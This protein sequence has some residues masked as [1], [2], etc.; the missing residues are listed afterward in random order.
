MLG[1]WSLVLAAVGEVY[2]LWRRAPGRRGAAGQYRAP[3]NRIPRE[4]ETGPTRR[5][6]QGP[7]VACTASTLLHRGGVGSHYRQLVLA[8]RTCC[9]TIA[10]DGLMVANG[11]GEWHAARRVL[12][13]VSHCSSMSMVAGPCVD[14]FVGRSPGNPSAAGAICM[15]TRTIGAVGACVTG[16]HAFLD[17]WRA[18]RSPAYRGTEEGFRGAPL[19]AASAGIATSSLGLST[20]SM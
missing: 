18:R 8:A 15:I 4:A 1:R 12:R 9:A 5:P 2:W 10:A 7:S 19:P 3:R 16:A 13:N 17:A 20:I 11:G 14:R 6:G